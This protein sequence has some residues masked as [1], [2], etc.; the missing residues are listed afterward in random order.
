MA[1]NQTANFGLNQ[2]EATDK[3]LRE[4]FNA[5]NAKIEA[6]ILAAQK[7]PCCVTGSYEGGVEGGVT[8]ELGF[9]PSFLFVLQGTMPNE[10]NAA[11]A[12]LGNADLM[13]LI[14]YNGPM[15]LGGATITDTG[16]CVNGAV[17]SSYALNL[18][19]STYYYT[20]FY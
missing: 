19:G 15:G 8:V 5:D 14:K 1:S 12:A 4:E 7:S 20:A 17:T 2:W 18:K 6:A 13:L 9:K 10:S 16:F 3:V 11:V